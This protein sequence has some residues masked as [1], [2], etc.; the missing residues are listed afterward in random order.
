MRLAVTSFGLCLAQEKTG[1]GLNKPRWPWRERWT[2]DR[3]TTLA[4]WKRDK[5]FLQPSPPSMGMISRDPR[6]EPAP[7]QPLSWQNSAST[8]LV[9]LGMSGEVRPRCRGTWKKTG[10][11]H[12]SLRSPV[13][14]SCCWLPHGVK[15]KGGG[16]CLPGC[17][18]PSLTQLPQDRFRPSLHFLFL[19]RTTALGT[20]SAFLL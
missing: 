9:S 12:S 6:E 16:C 4:G 20:L 17:N 10:L 19:L 13:L 14:H 8:Q 7:W 2:Q 5:D 3:L 18:G 15:L 1:C 11:S